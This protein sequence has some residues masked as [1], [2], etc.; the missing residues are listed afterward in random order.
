MTETCAFKTNARAS[1]IKILRHQ[2]VVLLP[3]LSTEST[4]LKFLV[5][6]LIAKTI[7]KLINNDND[8]WFSTKNNRNVANRWLQG[9]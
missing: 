2:M 5:A 4:K 1:Q 8:C 9:I 6:D 3:L 7:T